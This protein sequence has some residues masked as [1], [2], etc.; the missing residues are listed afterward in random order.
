MQLNNDSLSSINSNISIAKPQSKEL[1]VRVIQFGTGNFLRAFADFFIDK[2]NREGLFDGRILAV[3]ST[4]STRNAA[5]GEQDYLYT[6]LEQG[7]KDGEAAKEYSINGSIADVV[8]AA[9]NWSDILAYAESEEVTTVISNTTEVGIQLNAEDK[10]TAMPPASFPGKLIAFLYARWKKFGNDNS[11][12]LLILPCELLVDNGLKLKD[13]V[14]ELAKLNNLE[15]D[16]IAWLS[17]ANTFA[18]T[19]VDRIVP[20]K[21]AELA[22][23]FEALEYEDNY[24]LSSEFFRLWAIEGNK[25]ELV[26][27]AP[28]LGSDEG[29]VIADDIAPFRERK[30]RLLN[31]GHTITVALGHL[32][33]LTT[34]DECTTDPIMSQFLS[35][36][37][38][39]EIAES[40]DMPADETLAFADSVI[41]R[42]QNPFLNHQLLAICLEYSMKMKMRNLPTFERYYNKTGR[43][44]KLMTIG[45]AAYLQFLKPITKGDKTLGIWNNQ[46]YPIN[47][48]S[49][50]LLAEV[51]EDDGDLMQVARKAVNIT[52]LWG[53]SLSNL[54]E[55]DVAVAEL[56]KSFNTIGIKATLEKNL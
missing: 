39:E 53:D 34:V 4:A 24:L 41:T 2:A 21:P 27:K 25:E 18:N 3:Q 17:S 49:A 11:K 5:F 22:P 47:D 28:F 30:L 31:G 16:F 33:G 23:H 10:V 52:K 40:L 48:S 38:K 13:I 6:L 42:F 26:A 8:S 7:I 1:P 43:L 14:L 12:G 32:Y 37:L 20:G 36:V 55:F 46:E 19:L 44:P 9:T 56:L 54:P 35:R 50:Q 45:F 29:I 51:W 15:S